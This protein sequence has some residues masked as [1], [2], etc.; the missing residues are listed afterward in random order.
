M[1]LRGREGSWRKNRNQT[2]ALKG[3]E[4][5]QRQARNA[6][7]SKI[8]LHCAA[9]CVFCHCCVWNNPLLGYTKP[10]TMLHKASCWARLTP[11][12]T[13]VLHM[14]TSHWRP[15]EMTHDSTVTIAKCG[16][17]LY[18]NSV[19]MINF[20]SE[21]IELPTMHVNRYDIFQN[22]DQ[23]ALFSSVS[24]LG[25]HSIPSLVFERSY[26]RK[27]GRILQASSLRCRWIFFCGCEVL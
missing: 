18:Q 2:P 26:S 3:S 6:A 4:G 11:I 22:D 9:E 13:A 27:V 1:R 16:V 8:L 20:R 7:R 23:A 17:W 14:I 5:S 25:F 24:F 10:A 12:S 15:P 19:Y 21:Y